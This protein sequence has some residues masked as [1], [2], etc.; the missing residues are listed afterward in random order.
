VPRQNRVN[1]FGDILAIAERGTCMG[2]RG[3]LHDEAGRIRR[4]WQVKRWLVCVLAFRG[5]KRSVMTPS[6][7]TELFFL[8]EATALAAG[9]RPCAECRHARFMAFCHAWRAAHPCAD[10]SSRPIATAIDD[11][12]H[13]ERMAGDRSKRTFTA[14]LDGLPDGVMVTVE[15]QGAQAYLV[16]GDHLLAWSPQGYCRRVR[17]RKGQEVRVLTPP[18]TVRTIGAGYSPDIHPSAAG[19]AAR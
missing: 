10:G 2:N 14:S 6:R 18:S 16:W 9:H 17:R 19:L 8:D 7:Y 4:S 13:A 12:L 3:V 11:R 5:R 1:P 15:A